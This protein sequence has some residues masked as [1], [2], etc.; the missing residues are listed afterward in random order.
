MLPNVYKILYNYYNSH[1]YNKLLTESID[2]NY[3][4]DLAYKIYD[5]FIIDYLG[6]KDAIHDTNYFEYQ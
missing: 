1:F 5:N 6:G 2:N 3:N 4:K